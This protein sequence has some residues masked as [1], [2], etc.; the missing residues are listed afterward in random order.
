M[1]IE[2]FPMDIFELTI[3]REQA[4]FKVLSKYSVY[5]FFI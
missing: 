3:S 2:E 1:P 5:L 4:S